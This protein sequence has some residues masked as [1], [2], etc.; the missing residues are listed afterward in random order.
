MEKS[1]RPISPVPISPSPLAEPV[2]EFLSHSLG[3]LQGYSEGTEC[4]DVQDKP[5]LILII[6]DILTSINLKLAG[7]K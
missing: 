2:G 3:G 7:I 4:K 5:V 6:L 1:N